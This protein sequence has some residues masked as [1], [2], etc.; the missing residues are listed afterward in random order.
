MQQD[1]RHPAVVRTGDPHPVVDPTRTH[2]L[3][4]IAHHAS[5]NTSAEKGGALDWWIV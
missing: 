1:Q 4:P 3:H 5:E 2:N